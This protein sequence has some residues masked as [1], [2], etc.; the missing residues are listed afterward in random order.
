MPTPEAG[1][2]TCSH[3]L[4]SHLRCAV[5]SCPAGVRGRRYR[6]KVQEGKRVAVAVLER[7]LTDNG[8]RWRPEAA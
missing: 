8:W 1:L 4:H 3:Q 5:P 2:Y 6:V 7:V